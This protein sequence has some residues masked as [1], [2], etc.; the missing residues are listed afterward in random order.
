MR[1]YYPSPPLCYNCGIYGHPKKPVEKHRSAYTVLKKY[2]F[3]MGNSV[4]TLRFVCSV[5]QII[6]STRAN[7]PSINKKRKSSNTKPTT[8]SLSVKPAVSC[9]IDVAIRTLAHYNNGCIKLNP[10]RTRL[11]PT[12]EKNSKPLKQN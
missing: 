1:T 6:Q 11:L 12:L 2:I 3:P 4:K 8:E 7:V 5:R 9:A 10:K